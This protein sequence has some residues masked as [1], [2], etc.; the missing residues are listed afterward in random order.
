MFITFYFSFVYF[1]VQLKIFPPGN[2]H[3]LDFSSRT[4]APFLTHFNLTDLTAK[5]SF[6]IDHYDYKAHKVFIS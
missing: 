5:K 6:L 3:L 1:L 2:K 4:S